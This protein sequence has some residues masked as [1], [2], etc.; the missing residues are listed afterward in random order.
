MPYKD[1]NIGIN[2]SKDLMA[3][4]GEAL[5]ANITTID[6]VG[7]IR[8]VQGSDLSKEPTRVVIR[9]LIDP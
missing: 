7:Q 1:G 3:I 4:A 5:K 2:L 9:L 6:V 8:S